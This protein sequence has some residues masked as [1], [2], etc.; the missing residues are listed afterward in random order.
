MRKTALL[1]MAAICV[2]TFCLPMQQSFAQG[3]GD[4]VTDDILDSNAFLSR[5]V[6]HPKLPEY[7]AQVEDLI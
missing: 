7:S 2:Q 6:E 3:R 5:A 1:V 4:V